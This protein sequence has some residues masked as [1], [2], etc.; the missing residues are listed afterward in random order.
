MSL[1]ESIVLWIN[2]YLVQLLLTLGVFLF[3][4]LIKTVSKKMIIQ[5][6]RKK[7][8]HLP[9]ELY[10]RKLVRLT[11]TILMI[12]VI[13]IIWEISLTGLSIYFTSIFTV[14]GVG[15]FAIWSILSNMTASILIFFFFPF[16]IGAKVKIIDGDNS[17]TGV[18][19]DIGL[20]TTIVE[21]SDQ[22]KVSYPN[23]LLIQRPVEVI[24]S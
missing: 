17:V 10:I 19:K 11:L 2:A 3:F 7:N 4:S 15:L 24:K 20:F 21:L 8:V 22:A 23:N 6:S 16:R 18:I 13:G 9:R 14:I 5:H 1:Y 12:T